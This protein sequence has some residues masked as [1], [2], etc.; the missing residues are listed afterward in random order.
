TCT[1]GRIQDVIIDLRPDSP[2]YLKWEGFDLKA[3]DHR[4]LYIPKGFAHGYLTLEDAT[5]VSYLVSAAYTPGAEGGVRWDDPAFGIEWA[6][7][8]SVISE[9]DAAWPDFQPA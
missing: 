5:A 3:G 8:V 2:T 6:A 4:Q 1:R 7:E 9:K